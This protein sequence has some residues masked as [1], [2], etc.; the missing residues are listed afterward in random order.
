MELFNI[1]DL[2]EISARKFGSKIALQIKSGYSFS[3]VTYEQLNER[4]SQ[5]AEYLMSLGIKKGD[6][7]AVFGENRPE[8]AISYLS[9]AK[10]GAYIIPVDS[11]L[12]EQEIKLILHFIGAKGIIVSPKYNDLIRE[13]KDE[14]PALKHV[15]SMGEAEHP[16][17]TAFNEALEKGRMLIAKGSSKVKDVKMGIDDPYVIIFTSGTT[18]QSK[19]VMLTNGNVSYDILYA[20]KMIKFSESDRFISMLPLHHTFEATAGFLVPLSSGCTITYARSL[21]P[22]EIIEDIKDSQST[23]MLGVPLLFEKIVLGIKRAIKASLVKSTVVNGMLAIEKGSKFL[24]GVKLAGPIFKSLREQSGLSSITLMI[25]G[26]SA[27]KPEVA[28]AFEDFG[29]TLFQ[30]YGLT[31]TSPIVSINLREKY[32]H[33]S[34]G[35]PLEGVEVEIDSPNDSGEGELK[36]RGPIVMKGYYSNQAATDEVIR[37]GW[38]YTGDIGYKDKEGYLYISGRKK[39]IIVTEAGKNVYP[40]ELEERLCESNMIEEAL[41]LP[42]INN[43]TKREEVGAIIYPN[44]ELIESVLKKNLGED[45]TEKELRKIVGEVISS[46]SDSVAD[47][48]RIKHFEIR[49]EEFTKT[50]TKKIKRYLFVNKHIGG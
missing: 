23:I 29:F 20:T 31:E 47:Y 43:Q 21:K 16:Y 14:L 41:V 11:M 1:R 40:E 7:F 27:L 34:I 2:P 17:E 44:P 38:F 12:K 30:G 46:V 18:G 9:I 26:G 22:A 42:V 32:K 28:Q 5:M 37:G 49:Y 48:K 10:T 39:A 33:S 36:V 13:I 45:E 19:G 4:T 35:L 50:T 6:S 3:S 24:L 25:S 8:W 15:I